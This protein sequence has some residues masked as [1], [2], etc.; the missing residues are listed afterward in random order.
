MK[1]NID[2]NNT[3]IDIL[4]AIDDWAADPETNSQHAFDLWHILSALRGPDSHIDS[5]LK[6]RSTVHIRAA[7]LPHL[8]DA[9]GSISITYEP[10]K[11][12]DEGTWHFLSHISMASQ[13]LARWGIIL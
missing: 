5:H 13:A 2:P 6:E 7:V 12:P 10:F 4:K 11:S 1:V 3:P 9:G 8:A